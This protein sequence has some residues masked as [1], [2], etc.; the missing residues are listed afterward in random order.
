MITNTNINFY[1]NNTTKKVLRSNSFLQFKQKSKLKKKWRF[2]RSFKFYFLRAK[3]LSYFLKIKWVFNQNRIIWHHF[4]N[5]YGKK[6]KYF[7]FKKIK[8]NFAFGKSFFSIVSFLEL[9][10]NVLLLRIRFASKLM[11]A[12]SLIEKGF[13]SINGRLKKKNYLVCIGDIIKK[14]RV[15]LLSKKKRFFKKKWRFFL[16]R[17]WRN[18]QKQKKVSLSF[19]RIF[20][21]SKIVLSLN[22]LQINYKALTGIVLRKPIFG[23][24]L[25]GKSKKIL[26]SGMLKK[27]Y[28]LY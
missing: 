14:K 17:K 18:H 28:F 9:R 2:W 10:L 7:F 25:V 8:S 19:P 12:N 13:I 24:V 1:L 15:L 11:I 23:E 6:M 22:Y 27:I 20:W 3:S 26:S 4:S 5:L 21:F 16:W